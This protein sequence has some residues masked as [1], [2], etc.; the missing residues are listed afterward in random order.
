MKI[1]IAGKNDIAVNALYYVIDKCGSD[2]TMVILNKNDCGKDGWQK[3]LKRAAIELNVKIC[4]LEDVYNI[5]DLCFFSLEFDR[6]IKTEKF[7]TKKLFNIHFSNLP[8]YKGMYTSVM[9]LLNGES[10]TGVTLHIIDNGI[11]TG[12]IVAWKNFHIDINDTSRDIY[13]KFLENA[14]I[15]F[16]EN[17]AKI[18]SNEYSLKKQPQINSSY[19]SKS[20]LNFKNIE[21]N[22]NKTSFEIHNQLRAF[23]FKEY[24]LPEINGTKVDKSVL[25]D[26][27]IGY[28]HFEEKENEF[29]ISGIDGYKISVRKFNETIYQNG[30]VIQKPMN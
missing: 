25:T 19:Y 3:S 9:P 22:F 18:L 23:M 16:K 8:K 15:L 17:F 12:D 11:D 13:F 14:F 21:I 24:Q 2:N 27:F 7:K 20:S 5:S 10:E 6:I 28:N 26:S 29:I 1:C 4:S 30:S